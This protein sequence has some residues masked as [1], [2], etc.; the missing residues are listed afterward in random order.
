MFYYRYRPYSELSMKEL[1]YDEIY[2]SSSEESNDPYE[3]KIF[4][5]FDKS[6]EKWKRLLDC[7]WREFKKEKLETVKEVF[8]QYLTEKSPIT[9]QEV[10][11]L[12]FIDCVVKARNQIEAAGYVALSKSLKEYIKLYEPEKRYFVSFSKERDNYLLWSHYANNHKGYCLIFKTIDG[13]ISQSSKNARNFVGRKTPKSFATSMGYNISTQFSMQD[14]IYCDEGETTVIDAFLCFP[15][16]VAGKEFSEEERA[17][18]FAKLQSPFLEKGLCWEYERE[19]RLLLTTPSAW[20]FGENFE[21]SSYERLFH[22]ESTQLVGIILGAKMQESEKNRIRE[23][24]K[25]KVDGWYDFD[26]SKG[27]K[28]IFS[29]VLFE[30]ELS[31]KKRNIDIFPKE[32]YTGTGVILDEDSEFKKAYEEWKKGR[33]IEWSEGHSKKTYIDK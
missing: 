22:Y 32:I 2:F 17:E 33:C 29:F 15:P 9:F 6:E 5:Q 4:F 24:V 18:H 28:R 8:C 11:M 25:D 30:S 21:Y 31:L 14:V 26:V 10:Q 1:M 20:L 3:G 13:K 27:E 16:Y 12:D 19:S 7:A 23:I